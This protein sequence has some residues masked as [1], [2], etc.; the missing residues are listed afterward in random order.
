MELDRP[1]KT[2][3][4]RTGRLINPPPARADHCPAITPRFSP[5]GY[6]PGTASAGT[7]RRSDRMV[8]VVARAAIMIAV[9]YM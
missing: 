2:E 3:L 7:S 8:T 1:A 6:T 9:C 5:D 4:N